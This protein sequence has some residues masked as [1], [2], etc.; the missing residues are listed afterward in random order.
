MDFS[1]ID[2]DQTLS[3]VQHFTFGT[4]TDVARLWAV[5]S[6]D[7]TLILGNLDHDATAEIEVAI[8]DGA[9]PASDYSTADFA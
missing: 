7:L 4:S 2:A 8:A 3:G 9:V 1:R 5:D 6:G